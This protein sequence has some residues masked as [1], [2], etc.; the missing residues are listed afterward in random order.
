MPSAEPGYLPHRHPSD[1]CNRRHPPPA[2]PL[3]AVPPVHL[4][5][6]PLLR[7]KFSPIHQTTPGH[8]RARV[9]VSSGSKGE[10]LSPSTCFPLRLRQRTCGGYAAM[11]V[12]CQQ[13][14]STL[15]A[16]VFGGLTLVV[17]LSSSAGLSHPHRASRR[18][19][20][21]QAREAR[22]LTAL[23]VP[24]VTH[25]KLPGSPERR[26]LTRPRECPICRLLDRQRNSN[27]VALCSS[28]PQE[29]AQ[30]DTRGAGA[31]TGPATPAL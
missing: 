28:Q 7:W 6:K 11:T 14:T 4:S 16:R 27:S 24:G 13:A 2:Q 20:A 22:A 15:R 10:I 1:G 5:K 31:L 9:Y 3:V 19:L 29:R 25:R 17:A 23:V 12:S 21:S 8:C 26:R 30:T 18:I